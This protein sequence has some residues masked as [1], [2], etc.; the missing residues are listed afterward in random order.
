[1]NDRLLRYARLG[2]N[3]NLQSGVE[4]S[5]GYITFRINSIIQSAY[6]MIT[7]KEFRSLGVKYLKANL[8]TQ[9]L[10]QIRKT[11]YPVNRDTQDNESDFWCLTKFD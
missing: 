8:K 6:F 5:P 7:Y 10:V 3:I 1:M 9:K 2:T 11:F 4:S